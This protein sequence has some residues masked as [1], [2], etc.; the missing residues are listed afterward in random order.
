MIRT[1]DVFL[2]TIFQ[3]FSDLLLHSKPSDAT[4]K[5]A[6]CTSSFQFTVQFVIKKIQCS[7]GKGQP[8][9]TEFA[10]SYDLQR[11]LWRRQGDSKNNQGFNL[12]T[13]IPLSQFFL[14]TNTKQGKLNQEF[15]DGLSYLHS[16]GKTVLQIEA[17]LFG[18]KLSQYLVY[19]LF[20]SVCCILSQIL[21]LGLF[22]VRF[23]LF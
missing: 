9:C 12:L 2:I 16:F 4:S 8:F 20:W 7:N 6:Q 22:H 5:F 21:I 23:G 1:A 13:R 10:A 3:R 11:R 18:S 15:Q 17:V 14:A 19:C